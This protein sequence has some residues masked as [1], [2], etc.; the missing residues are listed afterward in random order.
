MSDDPRESANSH[1]PP[2]LDSKSLGDVPSLQFDDVRVVG[3]R[4]RLFDLVMNLM[5]LVVLGVTVYQGQ[6]NV[7]VYALLMLGVGAFIVNFKLFVWPSSAGITEGRFWLRMAETWS[8]AADNITELGMVGNRL[9]IRLRDPLQVR[10]EKAGRTMS[11][12]RSTRGFHAETMPNVFSLH[13]TNALRATLHMPLQVADPEQERRR[14]F[15]SQ[16]RAATPRLFVTPLLIAANLAVFIWVSVM[17][18]SLVNPDLAFMLQAGANYPPLTTTGEWWRILTAMFLHFGVVHLL[19][20]M[21]ILRD[22]GTFV[23]R[24]VGNTGFAVGYVLSGFGGGV[25]SAIFLEATVSAGAS[26]AVFGVYGMLLGFLIWHRG[27]IPKSELRAHRGN[28]IAFL[29]FN[30]VLG[31]SVPWIDMAAHLGGFATGFVCGLILS[32]DLSVS[33]T[34]VLL[35]SLTLAGIGLAACVA[36]VRELPE[37]PP[38]LLMIS[39]DLQ[40][41]ES[42]SVALYNS[43]MDALRTEQQ[44]P[45]AAAD[46]IRRRIAGRLPG[47]MQALKRVPT[48]NPEAE[49]YRQ[50][51]LE[52]LRLREEGWRL[53]AEA[54]ETNSLYPKGLAVR[55]FEAAERVIRRVNPNAQDAHEHVLWDEI[56][57]LAVIAH[58]A[59]ERF[60]TAFEK[61]QRGLSSPAEFADAIDRDVIPRW[62]AG[63]QRFRRAQPHL[64]VEDQETAA[65]LAEFLEL[66]IRGLRAL[67]TAERDNDDQKR[68][69]AYDLLNQANE[70]WRSV[71]GAPDDEHSPDGVDV[72]VVFQQSPLHRAEG[73]PLRNGVQPAT[74]DG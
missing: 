11:R 72:E 15:E 12:V 61:Q 10:P 42:E 74:F 70:L 7:V 34:R 20:N 48:P 22:I 6:G 5:F 3:R 29:L 37:R 1:L 65:R 32:R 69:Q 67:S 39:E 49:Q 50:A 53:I 43:S 51:L 63:Q 13:D 54:V 64:A 14:V 62:L 4:T 73:T 26:G 60:E 38:D 55:K 16:L 21:W 35:R 31:F 23:E 18:H 2:D 36:A 56:A 52:Y 66:R 47:L 41:V 28:A 17:T 40:R 57:L 30:L 33:R 45:E 58:D 27:A 25:C 46:L 9:C 68:Q 19:F 44:T 71:L 59:G 8:T 24:L